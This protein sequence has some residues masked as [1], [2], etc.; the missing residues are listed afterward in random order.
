MTDNLRTYPSGDTAKGREDWV[1]GEDPM[2][3]AQA[4]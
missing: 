2:T 1:S 3:G 4:S